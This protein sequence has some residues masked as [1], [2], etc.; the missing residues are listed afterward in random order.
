MMLIGRRLGRM[1]LLL[2]VCSVSAVI[3]L[4]GI[5]M[6]LLGHQNGGLL[7]VLL[8]IEVLVAGAAAV[9]H[10]AV[11]RTRSR[12]GEAQA[13]AA[14]PSVSPEDV[15]EGVREQLEAHGRNEVRLARLLEQQEAAQDWTRRRMFEESFADGAPGPSAR[16]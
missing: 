6:F 5:V 7:V 2:A 3:T 10:R 15:I 9:L 1:R 12:A 4:L 14:G 16:E 8:A 11:L 13:A